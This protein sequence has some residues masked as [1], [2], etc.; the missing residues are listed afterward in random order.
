MKNHFILDEHL[1]KSIINTYQLSLYG[2]KA[3]S[4]TILIKIVDKKKIFKSKIYSHFLRV[5]KYIF[6]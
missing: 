3:I 6:L 1:I 4:L 2:R 5:V